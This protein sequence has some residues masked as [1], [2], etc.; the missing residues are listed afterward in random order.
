[1]SE[2]RAAALRDAICALS[3]NTPAEVIVTTAEAFYR[4]LTFQPDP[5]AAPSSPP[6]AEAG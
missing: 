1:M 4:F 6:P 5:S 2:L 3:T